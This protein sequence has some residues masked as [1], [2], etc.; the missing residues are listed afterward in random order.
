MSRITA[1]R[2]LFVVATV[3]LMT[4]HAFLMNGHRHVSQTLNVGNYVTPILA[5]AD[6]SLFKNS[7]YVQAVNHSNVRLTLFNDISPFIV[8]YFD[9]ENFTI[10]VEIL[11]LGF[12]LAGLFQTHPGTGRKYLCR[13]GGNASLYRGDK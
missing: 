12:I 5:K 7:Q 2:P 6:P 9:L 11:S 8:Q 3:L 4:V 10:A 1:S 13:I